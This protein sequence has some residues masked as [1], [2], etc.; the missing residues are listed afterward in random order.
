MLQLEER[1]VV[2]FFPVVRKGFA[3]SELGWIST[4]VSVEE[5]FRGEL[6]YRRRNAGGEKCVLLGESA[7]G[8]CISCMN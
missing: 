7:A 1:F 4:A 2:L 6:S 8:A 3:E 5:N